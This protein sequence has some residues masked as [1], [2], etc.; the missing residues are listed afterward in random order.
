MGLYRLLLAVAVVLSHL[1]FDTWLFDLSPGVV[2]VVSFFVISGYVTSALI[3][4]HYDSL[5]QAPQFLLDRVMRIFPQYL[6]Y[7]AAAIGLLVIG[8]DLVAN[9]LPVT[10]VTVALNALMLPTSYYMLS[11]AAQ[12][13]NPPTWTLGLEFTFYLF[14]P[15]LIIKR[16]TVAAFV[17]SM[18]VFGLAFSGVID[19][20]VYGYRLIPGTLFIF[21]C[22]SFMRPSATTLQRGLVVVAWVIA[23]A[24]LVLF[25]MIP[26]FHVHYN[27]ELATGIVIGVPAVALLTGLRYRKIDEVFGNISYGVYVNHFPLIWLFTLAGI[28]TA[29]GKT[30]PARLCLLVTSFALSWATYNLVERP[31]IRIRHRIRRVQPEIAAA[32]TPALQAASER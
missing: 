9:W 27:G 13:L 29:T 4:K 20:D 23:A 3:E 5:A 17:L 14:A 15:I 24:M 12:A 7:L 18:I 8:G 26:R 21:L 6:V 31:I 19:T 25:A 22:G 2:A 32:P 1:G 11:D 30:W 10:P 16:W 28:D